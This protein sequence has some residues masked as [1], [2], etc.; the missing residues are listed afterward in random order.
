[1][2]SNDTSL[3]PKTITDS[4][5]TLTLESVNW[6]TQNY[7]TVDYEQI[8]ETYTAIATYTGTASRTTITGYITTAEY[9][10]K[11]SKILT[12]K[13]VYTAYFIGVPIVTGTVNKPET[14]A[15]PETTTESVS[16]VIESTTE[17]PLTE[18]STSTEP[19]IT[20]PV[21]EIETQ[22]ETIPPTET[23][24]TSETE[25]EPIENA[26]NF[27]PVLL[28]VLIGAGIG[29]GFVFIYFQKRKKKKEDNPHE[30]EEDTD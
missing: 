12:G 15:E 13:T 2:S 25:A 5:R 30:D 28:A 7:V 24:P 16:E 4:G 3:I 22:T 14:T 19:T 9:R 8:P 26:Y 18:T 1:M 17:E 23:E 20:E 21:T 11:L 10:G 29:G 6:K 27:S